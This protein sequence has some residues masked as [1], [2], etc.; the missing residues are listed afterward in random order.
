MFE[1]ASTLLAERGFRLIVISAD[2]Q[3]PSA[4]VHNGHLQYLGLSCWYR[5]TISARDSSET[6]VIPRGLYKALSE[7]A[8]DI[9]VTEDISGL[10]ANLWIPF[11]R[12]TRGIPYLVWT[13]GPSILGKRR[14]AWRA[15][16]T[17]L[18]WALRRPASGF[19]AYSEWA[20]RAL[21]EHYDK[22]VW[23]APNSTASFRSPMK[24][25]AAA[26]DQVMEP[27]RILYIGRLT[28]QK[29]LDRLFQAVARAKHL[30]FVD[31]VGD[32]D[33][34]GQLKTLAKR[35][36]ISDR[37]I[38][39]GEVRDS[40]RKADLILNADVGVMPGLGGL[41]IQEVQS[42]GCPV[43]AGPADGTEQDLVRGP[44]PELYM[45]EPTSDAIQ[46][47]L[48]LL[49]DDRE[50]LARCAARAVEVTSS[51]YNLDNM[52]HN[53]VAAI[54]AVLDGRTESGS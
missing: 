4:Q 20:L 48:E 47:R 15:L 2:N 28:A 36:G 12:L 27:L 16:A 50:L 1:L 18:I 13:L 34:A 37:V 29:H 17:P 26:L 33:E 21:K 6:L 45:D 10:P 42:L 25:K 49:A 39:H 30:M 53:W 11:L 7:L 5:G 52:A 35:L 46:Q 19:I 38:F 3:K 9:I 22:P 44:N 24:R 14:S 40:D 41:F 8:P 54:V 32:G 43:I 31:V 51:S 23:V